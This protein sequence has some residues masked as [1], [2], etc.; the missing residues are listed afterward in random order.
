MQQETGDW[1]QELTISSEQLCDYLA[2]AEAKMR[3]AETLGQHS[4]APG[5]KKRKRS[6]T[7]PEEITAGDE[8]R[9]KK[10]E[11]RAA[12]RSA[13]NDPDYEDTS[14]MKSSSE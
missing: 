8:A 5:V 7:P 14:S 3:Q 13:Q 9:Y 11:E 6:E 12:K 1:D 2:A 4:I 10:R